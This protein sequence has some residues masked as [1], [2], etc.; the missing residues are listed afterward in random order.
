MK[1]R[2]SDRAIAAAAVLFA[3]LYA[4]SFRLLIPQRTFA[5]QPLTGVLFD[6]SAASVYGNL[7]H[8]LAAVCNLASCI[9][10]WTVNSRF[11]SGSGITL[12]VTYLFLISLNPETICFSPLHAA[13]PLLLLS[14]Y[15]LLHFKA[16]EPSLS[17]TFKCMFFL[18]LASLFHSHFLWLVPFFLLIN[19][20]SS[21]SKGKFIF[22]ALLS[23]LFPFFLIFTL[24]YLSNGMD[25]AFG[26]ISQ[27]VSS[28]VDIPHKVL[29]FPLLTLL[30]IGMF[31]IVAIAA[32]LSILRRMNYFRSMKFKSFVSCLELLLLFSVFAL[33]FSPDIRMPAILYLG[34]PLAMVLDEFLLQQDTRQDSGQSSKW[35][36]VTVVLIVIAERIM[37]LL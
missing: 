30:R 11:L 24:E 18:A 8:L 23:Y 20:N 17:S 10:L 27:F 29:F 19:F 14:I 26:L 31:V 35:L 9:I 12:P 13:T 25:T 5:F 1:G 22:T 34:I 3:L 37:L 16:V 6:S 15:Y 7:S 33:V 32:T 36:T 21:E 28:A 2:T 4:S